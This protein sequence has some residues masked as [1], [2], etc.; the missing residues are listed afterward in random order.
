[1][2]HITDKENCCGCSS[3]AQRC[4]KQCITMQC[5]SEGFL[6]PTVDTAQCIDCGLCE[7]VC[8]VI[9]PSQPRDPQKV[10]ASYNK[11]EETRLKS[12]SGG[13]FTLLA[14]QTI[15][16]GGVVFG[17][18]FDEHWMPIFDYTLTGDGIAAFRG[19]KYV[20]ATVG[21][22]Y[23]QAEAFLKEG[24]E[25]LFSG[26]PCQIAGLKHYLRKEYSNLLT[27]DIICHGVPSPRVWGMYVDELCAKES[28]R[29]KQK[30]TIQSV[31]FR[32]KSRGWKSF[33]I[34]IAFSTGHTYKRLF[35]R[36]YYMR[37][38][39]GDATL[40]PSCYDCKAKIG[41]SH[42]DITIA[43]FWGIHV[44]DPS[45][46]DDKGCGAIFINTPKGDSCYP[47]GQCINSEKSLHDVVSNNTSYH[48]SSQPHPKRERF[49]ATLQQTNSVTRSVQ[50][51]L[52]PSLARRILAR[53]KR[54]ALSLIRKIRK[55][56]N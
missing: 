56:L 29:S 50:K 23:R 48:T 11:D 7:K 30:A 42:S 4:P 53:I 18:R 15:D 6:Y 34:S 33:H 19:S 49:F 1:M 41:R 44:V 32:D 46:D 39:V 14:Q 24:R 2:I 47:Y 52:I 22:A 20:Q 54:H 28:R 36:D 55:S 16:K 13:I 45:L 8:P 3:C 12:S 43:D 31:S 9:T 25:V 38:F 26:T 21:N 37:T 40:R 17:V 27:V 5:D 51:V 35:H 10:Y